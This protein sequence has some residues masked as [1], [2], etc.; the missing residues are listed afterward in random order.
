MENESGVNKT[1]QQP[2]SPLPAFGPV[3]LF[4]WPDI[5]TDLPE[6]SMLFNGNVKERFFFI[7]SILSF[8]IKRISWVIKMKPERKL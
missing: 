2:T 6:D 7:H 4:K 3:P 5:K 1:E 8:Y